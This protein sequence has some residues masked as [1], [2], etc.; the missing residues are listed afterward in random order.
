MIA[1]VINQ[2]FNQLRLKERINDL[3]GG[4]VSLD[5]VFIHKNFNLLFSDYLFRIEPKFDRLANFRLENSR[6]RTQ[7]FVGQP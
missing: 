5:V 4:V 6:I 3:L 7:V 1:V 2:Q